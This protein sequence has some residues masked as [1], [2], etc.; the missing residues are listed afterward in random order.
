MYYSKCK[1]AEGRQSELAGRER[2]WIERQCRDSV[3][4]GQKVRGNPYYFTL[5]CENNSGWRLRVT[6][7]A[8]I[9][10]LLCV[11]Y[12]CLDLRLL[13]MVWFVLHVILKNI[14]VLWIKSSCSLSW[15]ASLKNTRQC[16][17]KDVLC[18]KQSSSRTA[19]PVRLGFIR[20][21]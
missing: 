7:F 9:K 1:K 14:A 8:I 20:R 19:V 12:R 5:S 13:A 2:K 21:C 16:S 18:A 10:R 6:M 11:F 17:N 3:E 15:F 4:S